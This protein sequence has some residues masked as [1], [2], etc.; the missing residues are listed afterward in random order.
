[1]YRHTHTQI[2]VE[3]DNYIK[4]K[5]KFTKKNTWN[6]ERFMNGLSGHANNKHLWLFL[7]NMVD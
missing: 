3:T 5:L 1:M 7:L 4:N 2:K 6:K